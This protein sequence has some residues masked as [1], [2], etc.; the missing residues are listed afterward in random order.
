MPCDA[1]FALGRRTLGR[2]SM[3]LASAALAASLTA[4][5]CSGKKRD[6]ASGPTDPSPGLEVNNAADAAS[7]SVPTEPN[8]PRTPAEGALSPSTLAMRDAGQSSLPASSPDCGDACSGQCAPGSTQCS[9]PNERIECGID[10]LWS[11][12]IACPYVCAEGTCTGE[13]S[14]GATECATSTRI[15]TCSEVG[16]WT[17]PIDCPAACVDASCTGQCVPSQTQCA[18]TTDVQ[19]CSDEGLWGPP[20]TC[21][22]ACAG[23]ACT[24]ECVPGVTRCISET[25]LQ[26]CNDQGQFLGGAACPF[27]CVNGECGGECSPGSRRCNPVSGVPQFC[28]SN[29]L[30]QSQAPCQFTCAGS[31]T[32][33]GECNPGSRRCDPL[34]GQPQLCSS[35]F[36]WQTQ[37]VCP[38]GCAE[39][40]CLVPLPGLGEICQA[41]QCGEGV[42]SQQNTCCSTSCAAGCRA[43]G[44]CDCPI[45]S[46][47]QGGTCD[48]NPGRSLC[49]DGLSSA[50][51]SNV[52][53]FEDGT[54]QGWFADTVSAPA[55]CGD[56][57]SQC[58]QTLTV[59][60]VA[61]FAQGGS[62][63][64]TANGTVLPDGVRRLAAQVQLCGFA[65]A[66]TN[67]VG[68]RVTAFMRTGGQAGSPP[69]TTFSLSLLGLTGAPATLLTVSASTIAG[70]QTTDWIELSAV[71]PDSP[72]ARE[73]ASVILSLEIPGTTLRT[74]SFQFDDVHVGE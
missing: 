52:F 11:Q 51:V 74:Q 48:C 59:S 18:S 7:P 40:S 47:F 1:S 12:P 60:D 58:L 28:G 72:V 17:D 2:H 64:A 33:S 55:L 23:G 71:V 5:S 45:N 68:Q 15:R 35:S 61:G 38:A 4:T 8:A 6:F 65:A 37:G 69:G 62:F 50:C 41:G 27:A 30:W 46:T 57:F 32:C 67:L 19:I 42:C 44:N 10:A 49:S 22:N 14:P 73:A 70:A 25:T 16:I 56:N 43:D 31:G 3:A 26:T 34:S 54:L 20:T 24:G 13:C 36:A 63:F 53:D 39:G 21:Q 29:G 9:S 66:T